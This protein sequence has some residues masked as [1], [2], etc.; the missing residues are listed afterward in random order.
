ME[1]ISQM[2]KHRA[3]AKSLL[4]IELYKREPEIQGCAQNPFDKKVFNEPF[5]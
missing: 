3:F 4:I 2:P 1:S 5:F